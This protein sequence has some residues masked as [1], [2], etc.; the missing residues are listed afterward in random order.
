MELV[1]QLSAVTTSTVDVHVVPSLSTS[2]SIPLVTTD[3]K[4]STTTVESV[5]VQEVKKAGESIKRADQV[6]GEVKELLDGNQVKEALQKAKTL[7]T[8]T[9]ETQQ[10]V[11]DT[12]TKVNASLPLTQITTSTVAIPK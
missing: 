8:L 11:V 1:K 10:V 4:I 12:Q 3:I 7:N 9:T 5:S 6:A 2:S